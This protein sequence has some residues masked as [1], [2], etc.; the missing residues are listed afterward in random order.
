[1]FTVRVNSPLSQARCHPLVALDLVVGSPSFGTPRLKLRFD[2]RPSRPL[3]RAC[4]RCRKSLPPRSRSTMRFCSTACRVAAHR[5]S[6]A[7]PAPLTAGFAARRVRDTGCNAKSKI[8]PSLWRRIVRLETASFPPLTRLR[9]T[10][11]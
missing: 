1:M 6:E 9:R 2:P 7:A 5:A 8:A 10:T 4:A 3:E 11:P